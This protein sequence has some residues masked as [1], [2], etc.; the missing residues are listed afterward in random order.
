MLVSV[1]LALTVPVAISLMLYSAVALIQDK[2]MFSS[3]PKDVQQAIIPR[4][5]ERFKGA[6]A[7]GWA[8]FILSVLM[9][10][11]VLF[12]ACFDGVKRNFNFLDFFVRFLIIL[13]TYK[14][15]D[16]I[17]FDWLLLTKMHF[18]QHYYP[19]TEGCEGYKK[20]GFNLRSQII[21]LLV[22]PLVAALISGIC[23]LF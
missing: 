1:I 2:R 18:F 14:A 21:K 8:L 22:F 5:Q 4:K 9:I 6:R 3:A 12:Y 17:C 23:V 13:Y 20:Y 11:F 10:V 16:M 19:E 15:Y 7:L